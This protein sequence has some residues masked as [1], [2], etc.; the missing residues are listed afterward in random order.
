MFY[1]CD[2]GVEHPAIAF[3]GDTAIFFPDDAMM[4]ISFM[5]QLRS[6]LSIS[7]SAIITRL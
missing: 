6:K 3:A 5:D 1:V 2:D 4:G 7:Q